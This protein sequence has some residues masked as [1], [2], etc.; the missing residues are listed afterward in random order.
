VNPSPNFPLAQ[1]TASGIAI[2]KGLSNVPN[3]EQVAHLALLAQ[4]LEQLRALL[5]PFHI[6]SAFR[7]PEVNAALGGSPTSAHLEGYAADIV[8][9]GL[10]PIEVCQAIAGAGI[11]F[12]QLIQEGHWTHIS[13]DPRL[14]QE[15]LTAHFSAGKVAYTVGLGSNPSGVA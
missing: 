8:C 10:G 6:D 1:L 14:R 5:G 3:D 9:P 15:I 11:P 7:S 2:R 12:D 13:V 4:T